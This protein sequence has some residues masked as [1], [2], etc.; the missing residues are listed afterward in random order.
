MTKKHDQAAALAGI[1]RAKRGDD[2]PPSAEIT[3]APPPRSEASAVDGPV[4][5]MPPP[6]PRPTLRLITN[7]EGPERWRRGVAAARAAI[8]ATT[9]TAF[10]FPR[11]SERR[12]AGPWMMRT[13]A[14]TS[15][16]WWKNC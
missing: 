9:N 3:A 10:I 16:N 6:L 12:W 13:W 11:R 5:M 14:K 15:V 2:P 7:R 1:L 4:P 8:Q